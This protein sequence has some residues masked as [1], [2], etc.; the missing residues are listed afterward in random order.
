MSESQQEH[1]PTHPDE[2]TE[3]L[4]L[5]FCLSGSTPRNFEHVASLTK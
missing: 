1:T 5:S 2:V 4:Y 3:N